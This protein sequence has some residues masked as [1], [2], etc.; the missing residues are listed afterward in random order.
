MTQTA[1]TPYI[2][3][4]G[5][6]ST[7]TYPYP[8]RVLAA[9]DIEAYQNGSQV[10]N[11]SV[12]N[13]GVVTGGNVVF[14]LAPAS[15]VVIVLRRN[16]PQ[17]QNTDYIANDPFSAEGHE[18]A[19]DKLTLQVQDIYE[20]LARLPQLPIGTDPARLNTALP[21]PNGAS[22][23]LGWNTAGTALTVFEATVS[24]VINQQSVID[25]TIDLLE[26]STGSDSLGWI[27][28]PSGAALRTVRARLRD[29]LI[30]E[31]FG[32]VGDGSADDTTAISNA[33]AAAKSLKRPVELFKTYKITSPISITGTTG[34]VIHLRGTGIL[35]A[36]TM[37]D[38]NTALAIQGSVGASAALGADTTEGSTTVT[39]ALSVVAGDIVRLLSTAS[40]TPASGAFV[41]GEMAEVASSG[42]GSIT[43]KSH[44]RD[45]YTAATTTLYK[46]NMPKVILEGLTLL[47]DGNTAAGITCRYIQDVIIDNCRVTGARD[48]GIFV[49][50]CYGGNVSN[51]HVDDAYAGGG[52]TN[53]SFVMASCQNFTVHGNR[54]LSGRHGISNGGTFPYRS[55]KYTGN[56]VDNTRGIPNYSFDLHANGQEIIVQGN[57]IHNGLGVECIDTIIQGNTILCDDYSFGILVNHYGNSRSTRY[58]IID[59]NSVVN[60]A[61]GGNAL[62]FT[63]SSAIGSVITSFRIA[64]NYLESDSSAIRITTSGATAAFT[65]VQ[66]ANNHVTCG[67]FYPISV[68]NGGGGTLITGKL[69]ISANVVTGVRGPLIAL[70]SAASDVVFVNNAVT[71]T[72]NQASA[73][74]VQ[75]TCDA[76]VIGNTFDGNSASL[77]ISFEQIGVAIFTGNFVQNMATTFDLRSQAA[78]TQLMDADNTYL[79]NSVGHSIDAATRYLVGMFGIRRI[80]QTTNATP[81]T[82]AWTAGDMSH[83]GGND[84]NFA[85]KCTVSGT[86]GTWV[87]VS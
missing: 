1:A 83:N 41:K 81:A 24:N 28:T 75:G 62:T 33:I 70:N 64:N 34:D 31:D 18:A 80:T 49:E 67:S 45:N 37:A 27:H 74:A 69:L 78:C 77:G 7:T 25:A 6:G 65:N 51:C 73:L 20:K 2:Y 86:P 8:W 66:I 56:T 21:P 30:A 57:T 60:L 55:I 11:F 35:D 19:L 16:V 59:G 48:R 46:M 54:F 63:T 13:I 15:G 76:T 26:M 84:S 23:L 85:Y 14:T 39:C 5:T 36:R 29:T 71:A 79:N 68:L 44:L 12:T 43:F 32:T 58:L 87:S 10:F 17:T 38:G 53:Y 72:T 40:F 52:G 4:V 82:L 42:G 50:E 9:S 3:Y 47:R 61:S 22:K